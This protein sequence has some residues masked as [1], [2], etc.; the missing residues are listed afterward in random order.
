MVPW[1]VDWPRYLALSLGVALVGYGAAVLI[2]WNLHFIPLIQVAPGQPPL[3]REAALCYVLNGAALACLAVGRRRAAFVC[4]ALVLLL[5]VTVGLEYALHLDLGVDRLLG[6]GYIRE[7]AEPAGRMSPIAALCYFL[8]SAALLAMSI[9]KLGPYASAIAGVIAS[10]LIAVGSVLFLVYRLTHLPVYGWGHF[11]HISMQ[12]SVV[13]ALFGAGILLL[14]LQES[15][16]KKALPNWLP[17]AVAL[18]LAAATVGIWQALIVHAESQLPLLSHLILVGGIL[19]AL[20]LATTVYLAQQAISRSR[21]L[22]EGKAEFERLFDASADA[23][24][25]VDRDRRIVHAN[26]RVRGLFG[27][28]SEELLGSPV[29]NLVPIDLSELHQGN[30]VDLFSLPL[31]RPMGEG[32]ELFGRRKDGSTFPAEVAVSSLRSGD[33]VLILVAVRDITARKQLEEDLEATR[34]QAIAAARLSALGMMAGGIAH[35]I[36]NPLG[37]IHSMA[38]DLTEMADEGSVTPQ[39][40]ARKGAAISETTERIARIVKSLRQISREG[41]GDPLRPTPLPKI[42]AETL[43]ICRAKFKANSVELFVPRAIPEVSVLCREVQIAQALLNLLQNAFDAVLDQEGERW[44]RL[45]VENGDYSVALSVID[46]GPGIP[47]ELRSHI[48]EPFF[49]TKPVGKGT[50][51]GLS[52]S[53]TIAEDHGGNLEYSED[54]GRTRFSLVL[55]LAGKADAA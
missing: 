35:E 41:A 27:Y 43:E 14:A 25:V 13:V 37:I 4:A 10:M 34:V 6:N 54:H 20:L 1:R 21:E 5:T 2:A 50:G 51:L 22:H 36:N 39:T 3:T 17:L 46:N 55:P 26:Q 16:T 31:I 53:K 44:V 19:G 9:R 48:G 42:V 12:A 32:T 29:K 49:T 8:C 40:V 23:L 33:E 7:G 18:G 52:L 30:R 15:R 11:R 45:E 47:A 28:T 38:S 24:L